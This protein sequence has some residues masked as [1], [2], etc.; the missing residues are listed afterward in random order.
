M[1]LT[2]LHK[3]FEKLHKT[4]GSPLHRPIYG[5]GCIHHPNVMF[6]F[7]NPTAKNISSAKNWKGLRAP[8]LGTKTI[9]DIFYTL[10]FIPKKYFDLTQSLRPNEWTPNFSK[11]L[12]THLEAKK[13]FVTNLA[14]C[15]QEDARPLKNNIFRAH[16]ELMRK[17]IS[18]IKP[19]HIVTFG[20]QISSIILEK[21]IS[22]G[23]Y[24][25]NQKETLVI[26]KECYSIYPT[27]YPVGQGRRNQPQAIKRIQAILDN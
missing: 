22:V 2:A 16:T 19:K 24:T 17:E 13:I 1:Q 25:K 20:N 15:T 7:M 23:S 10:N 18:L 9:W 4:Y 27:F 5:T 12:Y 21:S 8:W 3:N 26:G 14:K 6:I 11:K